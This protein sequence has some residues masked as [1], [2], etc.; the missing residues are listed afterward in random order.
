MICG[1]ILNLKGLIA[2]GMF[3]FRKVPFK[4]ENFYKSAYTI[5]GELGIW[6]RRE[7][8]IYF[9]ITIKMVS[10]SAA[11]TRKIDFV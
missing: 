9:L 10:T 6:S 11:F 7:I 3:T 8:K 4:N 2:L 5:Y 1:R